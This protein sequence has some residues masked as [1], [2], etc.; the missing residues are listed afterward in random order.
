MLIAVRVKPNARQTA[1][2]QQDDGTWLA[3]VNAPPVDGKANT[4]LIELVAE[5]FGVPKSKVRIQSGAGS[6]IKRIFVPDP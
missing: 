5:H 6:R 1:L 4:A 3:A 2:T